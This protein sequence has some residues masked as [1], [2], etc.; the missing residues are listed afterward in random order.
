VPALEEKVGG[1]EGIN[2]QQAVVGG[3]AAR[4]RPDRGGGCRRP[5]QAPSGGV[6]PGQ[7]S[8]GRDTPTA[9]GRRAARTSAATPAG[10]QWRRRRGREAR[11]PSGVED[12]W[13]IH[14]S[15]AIK[16]PRLSPLP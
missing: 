12:G 16:E 14:L 6:M 1:G 15:K 3:Q 4:R 9:D 8:G 2:W 7:V 11:G 10:A 13:L 5:S